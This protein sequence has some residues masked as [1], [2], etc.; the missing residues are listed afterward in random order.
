MVD[1][2]YNYY[3][4]MALDMVDEVV[5]VASVDMVVLHYKLV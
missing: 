5:M 4:N 1:N 2:N 3:Y